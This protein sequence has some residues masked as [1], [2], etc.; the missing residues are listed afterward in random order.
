MS[1]QPASDQS[2][3]TNQPPSPNS[4]NSQAPAAKDAPVVFA[5]DRMHLFV[6]GL[7]FLMVLVLGSPL[8]WFVHIPLLILPI[9]FMLWVLRTKTIVD[10]RGI[11]AQPAFGGSRTATWDTIQGVGFQRSKAFAALTD[12]TDLKLP[13]VSFNSLPELEQASA[14]RIPD[15]LTQGVKAVDEKVRVVHKDGHEVLLTEAEYAEYQ[16]QQIAAHQKK[17]TQ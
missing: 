5:P 15:A 16:R 2:P 7:L 1:E 3:S 6:A 10:D 14:G 8:P 17:T 4:A 12:G 11:T 13:A 9:I